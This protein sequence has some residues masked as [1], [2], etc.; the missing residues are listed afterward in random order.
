MFRLPVIRMG[1]ASGVAAFILSGNLPTTGLAQTTAGGPPSAVTTSPVASTA[2]PG[3]GQAVPQ[4]LGL[5]Q[6]I[7]IALANNLTIRQSQIQLQN[8]E[9]QLRQARL[10]RL[11]NVGAFVSQGYNSGRNINPATNN[12]VDQ[13]VLS[14]NFQGSA[15]VTLYNGGLLQ[16]TIRQNQLLK[17]SNEATVKATE[18]NVSLTVVQNYLNVL[19]GQEQLVV[20]QRQIEVSQ[21]QLDR[22]QRLVNAGS[23]PEA[24]LFDIRAQIANDELA[25][26]NA[27]NTID[28]AKLA[29]LQAMNVPAGGPGIN[30]F[31]VEPIA[32]PDPTL[33]PY[34]ATAQQV[35]ETAQQFVPDI[36]AADLQVRSD[37]VGV[38]VARANLLPSLTMNGNLST[39]YSNVG[40]QRMIAD[41]TTQVDQTVLFNGIP[42]TVTFVQER[43]RGQN[44]SFTE[45]LGNNLNRSINL[46]LQIP[47][48]NRTQA[49]T[50]ILTATLQ[51]QN[52]EIAAAN[53]RLQLRQ[54]IETAYTNLKASSNRYRA[55]SAQVSQLERAFQASESRFNAGALNSTDYNVAK[56]NLDRARASLVQAKYDYVFRVKILD[57]YQNK[58]LT[59]D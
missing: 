49:R 39:L 46:Q 19:T 35:F 1:L 31:E 10:N 52:S 55:T 29:L 12:F 13:G 45:Q 14:N 25:I 16:N 8:S 26:V 43:F 51:Q 47:I 11:P 48:F 28:L 41:G 37:A 18:N 4:R 59:F 2:A 5:Q 17:Q 57:F 54:T 9:A 24:N 22:T 15:Q 21:A 23:L 53:T 58:P 27:Q 36:K 56:S 30:G 32:V 20:A 3:T 40:R 42:Q 6:C 33:D 7:D 34:N 44:Y 50:R 38:Q